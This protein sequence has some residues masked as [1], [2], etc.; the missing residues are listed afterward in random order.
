MKIER[1]ETMGEMKVY[2]PTHARIHITAD[3]K[4]IGMSNGGRWSKHINWK[5]NK[6]KNMNVE[7]RAKQKKNRRVNRIEAVCKLT[8]RIT[9][10]ANILWGLFYKLAQKGTIW[11]RASSCFLL[12][13]SSLL[14]PS[15]PHRCHFCC[16]ATKMKIKCEVDDE[17]NL[18]LVV[19]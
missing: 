12:L 14:L 6:S 2:A 7:R 18:V 19:L 1:K 5:K 8:L 11:T 9:L 16:S 3:D 17:R 15:L 10:L 4:R 13:P